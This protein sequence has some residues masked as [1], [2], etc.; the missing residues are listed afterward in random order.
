MTSKFV[1]NKD[2]VQYMMKQ[3]LGKDFNQEMADRY[4]KCHERLDKDFEESV[5][6]KQSEESKC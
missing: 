1:S 3:M 6:L 4:T 2:M 5:G